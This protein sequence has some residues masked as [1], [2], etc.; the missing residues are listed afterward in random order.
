MERLKWQCSRGSL[1]TGLC[2]PHPE[3]AI[4]ISPVEFPGRAGGEAGIQVPLRRRKAGR[5]LRLLGEEEKSAKEI[6][7]KQPVRYIKN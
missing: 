6:K 5:M 2:Q 7:K 1:G 4:P 3:V